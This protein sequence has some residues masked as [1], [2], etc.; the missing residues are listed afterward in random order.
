MFR[1]RCDSVA[2]AV[3]GPERGGGAPAVTRSIRILDLLAERRGQTVTLTEIA[4]TL[5]LAKSSVS[6]LC[7]ALEE[8]GLVRRTAAGYLL[9]RRTVV[10]LSTYYRKLVGLERQDDPV[11]ALAPGDTRQ[12]GGRVSYNLLLSPLSAFDA[13]YRVDD[14][15]G[16]GIDTGRNSRDQLVSIGTTHNLS[17]KLRLNVALQHHRLETSDPGTSTTAASANSATLGLSYRF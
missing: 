3:T 7:A 14:T 13:F 9:G 2:V 11:S 17:P 15:R 6:N 10:V 16:L 5:G 8:G 1:S 12:I 4:R